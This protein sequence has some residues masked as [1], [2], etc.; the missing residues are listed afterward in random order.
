MER[1]KNEIKKLCL[2]KMWHTFQY[3][4]S[5]RKIGKGERDERKTEEL[6]CE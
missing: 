3:C 4:V 2:K 6:S 1:K 5:P